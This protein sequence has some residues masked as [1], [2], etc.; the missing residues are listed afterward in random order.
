MSIDTARLALRDKLFAAI[1]R[2]DMPA[3]LSCIAEGASFR[4]GSAPA[5]VGHAAIGDA[6]TGFFA[7]IKGLKHLLNKTIADATTLVCEGEV[8]YTRHDGTQIVLPFINV[9]EFDD[10]LISDYR[11]YIDIAPLYA[12]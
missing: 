12:Q 7:T 5:V 4:F 9:F 8:S 1:D 10:K 11:I 2:Q 6:V 3:F